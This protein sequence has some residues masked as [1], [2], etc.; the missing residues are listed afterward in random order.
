M[1]DE[2]F[3][4]DA[5]NWVLPSTPG[6]K[7]AHA[8]N[9]S[10]HSDDFPQSRPACYTQLPVWKEGRWANFPESERW[11]DGKPPCPKCLR[12]LRH[13]LKWLGEWVESYEHL[14]WTDDDEETEND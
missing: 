5:T 1:S 14:T 9:W 12:Y 3:G 7:Y 6:S 8:P 2:P 13:H 4:I 11:A 10:V